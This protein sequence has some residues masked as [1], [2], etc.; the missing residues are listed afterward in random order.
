MSTL[1]KSTAFRSLTILISQ[2]N[3]KPVHTSLSTAPRIEALGSFDSQ[4]GYWWNHQ[5]CYLQTAKVSVGLFLSNGII[6]YNDI[7]SA[8]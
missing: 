3:K 1:I 7:S 2:L 8:I 6:S 5:L 4:T